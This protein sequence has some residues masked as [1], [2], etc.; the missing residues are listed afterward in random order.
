MESINLY[1]GVWD[2]TGEIR[3]ISAFRYDSERG[4]AVPVTVA[5]GGYGGQCIMAFSGNNML[6]SVT[7]LG[8]GGTIVSYRIAPD[9]SLAEL[10]ALQTKSVKLS[11]ICADPDGRYV[12]VSSMGDAT[13][14]MIRIYEDG[15]LELKDEQYLTGHGFTPRQV[16]AR[17]H[18]CMISPDGKYL[19]AANLGGDEFAL[20]QVDRQNERLLLSCTVP[21]G[22]GCGPR[23]MAFHP[24]GELLY[25][26]TEMGNRLYVFRVENGRLLERAVYPV[27]D[28]AGRQDGMCADIIVSRDGK[29][30]YVSNRGQDTIAVFRTAGMTGFFDDV[31]Y[32]PAG[33]ENPRGLCFTPDE[34]GVLSAN[35]TTGTIALMDRDP[36][37]GALSNPRIIAKV[38]KAGCVRAC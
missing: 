2:F 19:A 18:C 30:V 12:Y 31:R 20:F 34:L 27:M 28:P 22:A 35:H 25:A 33:G 13:V 16:S 21:A 6:V 9:G 8:S 17:I 24:S 38:P 37:S 4:S 26:L 36:E 1:C 29:Y 32:Y 3:G 7:E 11:Y 10:S 14:K 5:G 15:R 23:H